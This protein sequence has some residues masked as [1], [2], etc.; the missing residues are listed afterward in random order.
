MKESMYVISRGSRNRKCLG[1]MKIPSMV[2]VLFQHSQV[3]VGEA[4]V[5]N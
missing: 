1:D 2:L 3:A 4:W 5:D